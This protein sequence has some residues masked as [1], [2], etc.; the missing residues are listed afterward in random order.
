M[1][2]R[3]NAGIP[4]A[5]GIHP[6]PEPIDATNVPANLKGFRTM[7]SS[8]HHFDST[9][10]RAILQDAVDK[11]ESIAIFEAAGTHARTIFSTLFLP[12]GTLLLLPFMRPFH[13]SRLIWTYLIPVVPFVMFFDGLMSCL[14][15][16]SLPELNQLTEDVPAQEY[17]WSIGEEHGGLFP[18]AITY[19]IGQPAS[20]VQASHVEVDNVAMERQ[21]SR[22]V[23]VTASAYIATPSLC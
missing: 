22:R 8:F 7:F 5:H 18:M 10:A 12:L 17:K 11:K 21:S 19:L 16:Y 2:P 6:Y 9:E 4:C 15:A 13:W 1:Q 14:R 23:S 20:A 3:L